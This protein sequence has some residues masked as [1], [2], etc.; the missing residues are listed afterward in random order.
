[1]ILNNK[2]ARGGVV[3][4]VFAI[5]F[6]GAVLLSVQQASGA[7]TPPPP[8]EL[9]GDLVVAP[10]EELLPDYATNASGVTYGA[11]DPAVLDFN[12]P[13]L[14]LVVASN[15]KEGYVYRDEFVTPRPSSP[16]EAARLSVEFLSERTLTVYESDG[17]TP[18]GTYVANAAK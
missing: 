6:S 14:V 15:G 10:A 7:Q 4:A 8:G 5:A 12:W 11:G 17:V 13:Q 16:E 1:M 9:A 18:I 2:L 3:V